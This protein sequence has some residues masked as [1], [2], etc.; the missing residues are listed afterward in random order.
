[1]VNYL[2]IKFLVFSVQRFSFVRFNRFEESQRFRFGTVL[3]SR[4]S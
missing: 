3:L 2:M 4:Q 1:M